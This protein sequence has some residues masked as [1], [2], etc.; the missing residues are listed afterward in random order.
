ML[1]VTQ[2]YELLECTGAI[3]F[4]LIDLNTIMTVRRLK[5]AIHKREPRTYPW[6]IQ[7]NKSPNHVTVPDSSIHSSCPFRNR[8]GS[9]QLYIRSASTELRLHPSS[10]V[11]CTY[12]CE[13]SIAHFGCE[14]FGPTYLCPESDFMP[15]QN[16][17]TLFLPAQ[18]CSL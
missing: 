3:T 18:L 10:W 16:C 15:I 4:D 1:C 11:D 9:R 17:K 13:A 14:E 2:I 8:R 12:S 6:Y 7:W 5:S